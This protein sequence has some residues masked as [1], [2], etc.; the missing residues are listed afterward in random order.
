MQLCHF[1]L[2]S[3]E[4]EYLAELR[5]AL[6]EAGIILHALL[7]DDGDISHPQYAARDRRWIMDWLRVA[8]RLGAERARV[9][10]GK[11]PAMEETMDLAVDNL[12]MLARGT[13]VRIETENWFQLTST[14]EVVIQILDR[15]EGS[16]GLCCDWGNWPRPFKYHA[17]PEILPRAETCH[18]KLDL[19]EEDRLDEEDAEAMIRMTVEAGFAGTYVIVNG[20]TGHEW[21]AVELQRAVL[22]Q[23]AF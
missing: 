5:Q 3:G 7:I 8:E 15:L 16:V 12:R 9:I 22:Q 20:G 19:I 10:A 14:P 21:D 4:D 17:L 11:Q 1:H 18:A 6:T 13:S 23:A 2:P